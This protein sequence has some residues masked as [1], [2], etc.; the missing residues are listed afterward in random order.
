MLEYVLARGRGGGL[1]PLPWVLA[2]LGVVIAGSIASWAWQRAQKNKKKTQRVP[3]CEIAELVA[4][5]TGRVTA[6]V[7]PLGKKTVTGPLTGRTCLFYTAKVEREVDGAWKVLVHE[8]NGVRFQLVDESAAAIVDPDGATVEL[9]LEPVVGDPTNPSEAAAAFL[10]LHDFPTTNVRYREWILEA[11]QR[12]AAI[13]SAA[14][15]DGDKKVHLR[16]VVIDG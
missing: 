5:G 16:R 1:V 7:A 11:G 6:K 9:D 10:K 15:A 3:A 12:V 13:A 8:S 14:K 4:K 2:I